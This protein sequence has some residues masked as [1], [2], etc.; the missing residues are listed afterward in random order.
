MRAADVQGCEVMLVMGDVVIGLKLFG[1]T[2]IVK[3]VRLLD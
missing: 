1:V 3:M 2:A